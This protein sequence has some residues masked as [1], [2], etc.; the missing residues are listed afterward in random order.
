AIAALVAHR[1]G[2]A[3]GGSR[4]H[5]SRI[6]LVGLPVV[7]AGRASVAGPWRTGFFCDGLC[8]HGGRTNPAPRSD[9][10]SQYLRPANRRSFC[11]G[12]F[13]R[14]LRATARIGSSTATGKP[15]D[16][17]PRRNRTAARRTGPSPTPFRGVGRTHQNITGYPRHGR[18]GVI[19]YP[20]DSPRRT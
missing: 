11:P 9:H 1:P 5:N 13:S 17:G 2:W 15:F 8:G 6:Y 12:Y 4:C 19:I 7:V 18:P 10:L 3:V 20:A 14:L 16:P